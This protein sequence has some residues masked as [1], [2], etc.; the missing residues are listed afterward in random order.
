MTQNLS[1]LVINSSYGAYTITFQSIDIEQN[2]NSFFLVDQRLKELSGLNKNNCIFISA[3]EVNKNLRLAED[4]V[5]QLSAKGMTKQSELVVIGGGFLQDIGTLVASL[6]MRGVHWSYV[7]TTL[8]AMGDSCIGGKSSI[9]AG[10]VKNLVGNFYPPRTVI[11][12]PSFVSTLPELEILAGISE[13]AKICFAYSHKSFIESTRLISSWRMN[14]DMD[15]LTH[16]IQLSLRCKKYFIEEDEF[17]KGVR[18]L[19]NFGH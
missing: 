12:D 18:K 4:V 11:I 7:P 17:D 13:I 6:Y 19:L 16:L 8:A 14:Q 10:N 3:E 9:N 1:D 2:L 15:S 5:I